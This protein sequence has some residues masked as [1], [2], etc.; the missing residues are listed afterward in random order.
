[1]KEIRIADHIDKSD[2]VIITLVG[3]NTIQIEVEGY[4]QF[5][6]KT[7]KPLIE[8]LEKDIWERGL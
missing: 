5:S 3:Y 7:V 4:P 1:M 8:A 2:A 6:R